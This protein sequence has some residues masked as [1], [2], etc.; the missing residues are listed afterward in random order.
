SLKVNKTPAKIRNAK[1]QIDIFSSGPLYRLPPWRCQSQRRSPQFSAQGVK[2]TVSDLAPG[3]Y[4]VTLIVTHE[5]GLTDTDE[6]MFS[7][8]AVKVTLMVMSMVLAQLNLPRI[9][10]CR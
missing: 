7:A 6:M 1:M 8:I 5:G 10:D 2:P 4:D 3:F 9:L